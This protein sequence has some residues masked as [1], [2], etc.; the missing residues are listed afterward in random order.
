MNAILAV[1][2]LVIK[3]LYRRKDF[4]V[5]FV[6]TALI[7]LMMGALNFFNDDQV[8]RYL[9]EICL[10]LIWISGLVIAITTTARQ[11]P[12]EREHR[13]IFPLL[14]KPLTRGQ[15]VLGKFLG[16]WLAT[17]LALLVFYLF[18]GLISASREHVWPILS[19]GQALWLHWFMLGVV[20]AMTLCGSVVFAAPS[21]NATIMLV[22]VIG[23]LLI[24]RYLNK[25]ALQLDQPLQ[26]LV[27]TLYYLIPHLE[28]FDVR[29]LVIHNWDPISW[30]VCG[31][32]T[33]Y[34]A[35]YGAIFLIAGWLV[36]RRQSLG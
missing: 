36:F 8:V 9:K 5:L 11:I 1:A 14:A 29:D 24:G 34:A 35:V 16:C 19:Y 28:F 20:I 17:G 7:T 30:W 25:V 32:A 22:V 23:I 13:T 21:S 2:T 27:Y 4:Y 31:G 33:L 12:A 26:T 6:L 18:F 15:L 10:L 3:E